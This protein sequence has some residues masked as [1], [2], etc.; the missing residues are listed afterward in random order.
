MTLSRT[1]P[2]ARRA[3]ALAAVTAALDASVIEHG[4]PVD[5]D[6]DRI[7]LAILVDDRPFEAV[8][9][10]TAYCTGE[11]ARGLLE[12]EHARSG[13]LPFLVADRITADARA[14]LN[15]AGWLMARSTRAPAPPRARSAGRRRCHSH[16]GIDSLAVPASRCR[17]RRRHGRVLAVRSSRGSGVAHSAHQC[18]G[19]GPVDHLGDGAAARGRGARRRRHRCVSGAVLGAR[20]RVANT[21]NLAR[22]HSGSRTTTNPIPVQAGGVAPVPPRPLRTVRRWSPLQAA[23]SSSTCRVRS[24]CRSPCAGTERPSGGAGAA[25]LAV[26]PVA[27]VV[28]SRSQRTGSADRRLARRSRARGRLGPR[29]GSCPWSRD[30]G[31][32]EHRW[33]RL[34]IARSSS[35]EQLTEPRPTSTRLSMTEP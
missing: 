34:A 29:A 4:E 14:V 18:V 6:G 25:V 1:P 11:R 21:S 7:R 5:L 12:R 31:R 3:D 10:V 8:I 9:T 17:A 24:M 30:P 27:P 2:A 28:K 32:V 19:S 22:H 13:E 23:R 20:S 15:E 26:A 33:R 35:S 16:A